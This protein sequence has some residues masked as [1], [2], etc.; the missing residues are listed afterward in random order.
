M[1]Q[2]RQRGRIWWVRYYRNGQLHEESSRSR[3]KQV[4][5]TLLKQREGDVAKGLP[6]SAK[7]G[8]YRFDDA[9]E[10]LLVEY[11][12]NRRKTYA[13]V[14]RRIE[15]H[16]APFFGGARMASIDT[17]AVLRYT[18]ARMNAD[19]MV[20]RAHTVTRGGRVYTIPE[21]QRTISGA[22]NG[23]IN[24]ELTILKRMFKLAQRSNKLVAA[25]YIPMLVEDNARQ[26]FFEDAQIDSVRQHLP[27]HL[28]NLVTFA[29]ETGWRKSEMLN[30]EWRSV[31]FESGAV[32]L[33]VRTTKNKH[34]R[35]IYMTARLRQALREQ[36]TLAETLKRE[37]G[38]IPCRVFTTPQGTPIKSFYKAWRTACQQA[39][40]PG[41]I[42]HDFR[43]TAIRAF[44][45]AD[46]PDSVAMGMSGHS[47]RKVFDRYD[48]TSASDLK[49]AAKKLDAARQPG[50]KGRHG[51]NM[52]NLPKSGTRRASA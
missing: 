24:R 34:G 19:T 21:R 1:G 14:K 46:I 42:L 47:T 7:M 44:V 3:K 12:V 39:G 2:L 38:L 16:L 5:T 41:R 18:Q 35:E 8:Q 33:D 50:P 13:D 52:D 23:E 28:R 4:A 31:D 32:T 25:P 22:S 15:K 10:M 48:I 9:A 51:Q 36:W 17:D 30:L 45:R 43:R 29:A 26:G 49:D 6:V 40:C 11:Q 27:A 37:Q 20:Y